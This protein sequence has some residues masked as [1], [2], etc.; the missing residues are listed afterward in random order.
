MHQRDRA[1][2]ESNDKMVSIIVKIWLRITPD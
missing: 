1:F 2:N